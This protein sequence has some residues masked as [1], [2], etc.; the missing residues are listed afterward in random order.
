MNFIL[1]L[2]PLVLIADYV[3][4]KFIQVENL[5]AITAKDHH[6]MFQPILQSS[7]NGAK[8]DI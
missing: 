1:S 4:Q 8:H 3:P 2:L 7:D 5:D 6:N